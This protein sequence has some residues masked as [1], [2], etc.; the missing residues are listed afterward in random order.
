MAGAGIHGVMPILTIYLPGQPPEDHSLHEEVVTIGRMAG[1]AIQLPHGSVSQS[2]AR[3][4]RVGS[5][6]FLKDLKS[7][8]GTLVNGQA[9]KEI[10]LGDG[11]QVKLGDLTAVFR[12]EGGKPLVPASAVPAK[13]Q[14]Q[15]LTSPP[16]S[17]LEK[18][19]TTILSSKAKTSV[20]RRVTPVVEVHA[21]VPPPPPQRKSSTLL[22]LSVLGGVAAAAIV[23]FLAWKF[24]GG[25]KAAVVSA[26][27]MASRPSPV[28]LSP[29]TNA[30]KQPVEAAPA[31][32]S[33]TTNVEAASPAVVTTDVGQSENRRLTELLATLRKPDLKERRHAAR[34]ISDLGIGASNG[35]LNLRLALV[36]D[37]D[38]EVH[39]W[40]VAALASNQTFEPNAIPVLI[41]GLK[42]DEPALRQRACETLALIPYDAAGKATV[43]PELKTATQD[44]NEE[45]RKAAVAALKT[46]APDDGADK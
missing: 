5:D 16:A 27:T 32:A 41:E 24:A 28:Q 13:P 42:R 22:L 12:L 23:G 15:P 1:N 10:Q 4:M 29:A 45:V 8:N 21:P 36:Q 6:F 30:P 37:P 9:I 26:T 44:E 17:E 34:A 46:I 18:A 19:D 20:L 14:A 25:D 2:H 38:P 40:L 33:P 39:V 11:D 43:V 7:T 35:V 3:I 31:I